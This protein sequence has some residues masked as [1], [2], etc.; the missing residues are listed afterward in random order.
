MVPPR[1]ELMFLGNKLWKVTIP[2][3]AESPDTCQQES[4]FHLPITASTPLEQLA[5]LDQQLVHLTLQE[6]VRALFP[7]ESRRCTAACKSS[8]LEDLALSVLRLSLKSCDLYR[9]SLH[10]LYITYIFTEILHLPA[11]LSAG[12]KVAALFHDIGKIHISDELLQKSSSLTRREF[13]EMKKHCAHGASMLLR[14]RPLREVVPLIFHH[15]ERWDGH[16]Y[17]TGL[18]GRMIPLGARIIAAADAFAV[19]TSERPYHTSISPAQALAE[20]SRC[21]GTQ[22]DP[23][24]VEYFCAYL[25]M[26]SCS[27]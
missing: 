12:I 18:Q 27:K 15:H 9:H 24:L 1:K 20:L 8:F 22:F 23:L 16:G 17:P 2:T 10:V 11:E 13:E 3:L 25:Q 21:A 6:A 5:S 19:M 4:S 26:K 7:L 14:I